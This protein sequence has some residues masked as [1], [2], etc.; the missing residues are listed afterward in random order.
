MASIRIYST[1]H[2]VCAASIVS[3]WNILTSAY[4]LFSLSNYLTDIRIYTGI[5][6]STDVNGNAFEIDHLIFHPRFMTPEAMTSINR[7]DIVIVK[8]SNDKWFI[9][10]Q[11]FTY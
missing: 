8:V 10:G 1:N 5:N 3:R 9:H 2:F 11:L 4:C 6:S 7:F